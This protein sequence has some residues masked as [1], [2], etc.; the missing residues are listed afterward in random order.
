MNDTLQLGEITLTITLKNIRHMHLRVYPPDGRVG[1]TAPLRMDPAKIRN[2]AL[3]KIDWINRQQKKEIA[4]RGMD[5][6]SPLYRRRVAP[7]LGKGLSP[8]ACGKAGK[9]EC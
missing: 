1:I 2:F 9:A 6:P 8:E 5:R 3:S 7:G 4:G